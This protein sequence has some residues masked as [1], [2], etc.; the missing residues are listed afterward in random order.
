MKGGG[1]PQGQVLAEGQSQPHGHGAKV[2]ECAPVLIAV[3]GARRAATS[4][5]RRFAAKGGRE[6]APEQ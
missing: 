2:V 4:H 6:T 1:R 3:P 5:Q